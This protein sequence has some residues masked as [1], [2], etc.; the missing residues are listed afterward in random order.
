MST[1]QS[2]TTTQKLLT[3]VL[4]AMVVATGLGNLEAPQP[5]P[6]A[7]TLHQGQRLEL[8]SAARPTMRY[9]GQRATG[10]SRI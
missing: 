3:L 5:S 1:H 4:A 6:A 2:A 10:A 7:T 8:R 9:L